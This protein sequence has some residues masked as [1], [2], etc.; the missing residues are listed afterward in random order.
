MG[1]KAKHAGSGHVR[2]SGRRRIL[3]LAD[4]AYASGKAV[5]SG[6]I[7]HVSLLTGVELLVQGH[8]SE[9][10]TVEEGMIPI[11]GID[12]I[13]SCFGSDMGFMRAVLDAAPRVPVVFAS[14]GRH[15]APLKDRRV[16]AI[17]CDH[18]AVAEAAAELLVRHGLSEFGYVGSRH[19]LAARSWDAER[20]AAFGTA[21]ARRGFHAETYSPKAGLPP[22]EEHAALA[23][24]L[25]ALP[26]PCGI[27]VSDDMRAM[28]VLNVCR[29]SGLAVP[30]QIQV[31][32]ADN[33]EWICAHT[34]PTLTSV[35][36]DFEGCG[37]RA[38]ETL[39]AMMAGAKVNAECRM[40]NAECAMRNAECRMQNAECEM[41][42]AGGPGFVRAVQAFGVK[43]VEQRM[44]T[45]DMHGSV[46]RAVRAR[47]WLR[48][49]CGA[50]F[51]VRQVAAHIGCS[52][53]MLQLS[54]KSVFDRTM[55]EDLIEMR[56]ELAKKLLSD[57]DI[58]VLR[59]PERCGSDAP[60][61]F[62]QFFKART[63]MTMLQYRRKR[64]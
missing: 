61:H 26:K 42:N 20:G 8:T 15:V 1:Y 38:A 7:R 14:V 57:T 45:T 49:N 52:T 9:M 19:A 44:S 37:Y 5:A 40:K 4:F 29:V 17:F 18:A 16:A 25:R 10:P 31:V 35:E 22:D 63:G 47:K 30:E 60:N 12:G 50:P 58:P 32:G 48:D 56:L 36:P 39:L 24:W 23:A 55:Q 6:V 64:G 34:S 43:R 53:R 11:S 3:L 59:I 54:Y 2:K 41:G 46:N 33:E 28:H 21:I 13:V 51:E 27:F 62:M